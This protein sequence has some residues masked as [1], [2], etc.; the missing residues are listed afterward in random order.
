MGAWGTKVLQNDT[1]LDE[2]SDIIDVCTTPQATKAYTLALLNSWRDE[3]R[4]L[5]GIALVDASVNSA[6]RAIFGR[7]MNHYKHFLYDIE[8]LDDLKDKALKCLDGLT[9]D[10]WVDDCKKERQ[11]LYDGLRM[12]LE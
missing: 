8:G 12:R 4:V 11:E 1:A 10:S 6:T 9:V 7:E 2:I 5:L 3:D